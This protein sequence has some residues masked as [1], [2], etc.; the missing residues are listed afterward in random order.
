MQIKS[1]LFKKKGG[2]FNKKRS[3]YSLPSLQFFAR[4]VLLNRF[5]YDGTG[6]VTSLV[7]LALRGDGP[8]HVTGREH[9]STNR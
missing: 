6:R 7:V 4:I 1:Q 3:D 8:R 9:E 5:R 2:F